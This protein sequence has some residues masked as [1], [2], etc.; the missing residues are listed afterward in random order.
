MSAGLCLQ[1][2][3]F[4]STLFSRVQ[5]YIRI[6]LQTSPRFAAKEAPLV[7]V[8]AEQPPLWLFISRHCPLPFL[9]LICWGFFYCLQ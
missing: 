7:R 8:P 9:A 2:I 3:A 1:Q 5:I 4:L 6:N